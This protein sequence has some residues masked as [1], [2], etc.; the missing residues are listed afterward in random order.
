MF[1]AVNRTVNYVIVYD[2]SEKEY[3]VLAKSLLD[4]YYKDDADYILVFEVT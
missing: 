3:Y 2:R 1:G 4:K